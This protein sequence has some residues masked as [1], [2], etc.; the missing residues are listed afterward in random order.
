MKNWKSKFLLAIIVLL[1]GLNALTF[2]FYRKLAAELSVRSCGD[3]SFI[4]PRY[5]CGHKP[6]VDK[7]G[8]SEFKFKLQNYID[9]KNKDGKADIVAV[10]F[11]DLESGPTFGINDRIDFIPASLLKLPM[12]LT[13][14]SLA[15][16]YPDFLERKINYGGITTQVADQYFVPHNKLEKN[17]QYTI[18]ELIRYSIIDSDNI[19]SQLIYEYLEKSYPGELSQTYRDLGILEPGHDLNMSVVNAKGYGSIFRMLYNISFLNQTMSE[20]LLSLLSQTYFEKGVRTG[21]PKNIVIAH[22][23]GERYLSDGKKQLH[24][25]GIVYYPSNPYQ[26]C[27]MTRGDSFEDLADT[28]GEISKMI[29]EEFDSRKIE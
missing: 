23:F 1:L 4:N 11:R 24:D 3:Y 21:V 27:I 6:T 13:Y 17:N 12:A 26:L 8:Y 5:V 22:K 14:F 10:W 20:K 28:I 19:A 9:Q 7:R 2:Y 18:N 15:E 16:N 25:C 29:Y